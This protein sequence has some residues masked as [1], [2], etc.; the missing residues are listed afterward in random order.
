MADESQQGFVMGMNSAY[1]SLGNIAG[2]IVAGILFDMDVNFPYAAAALVMVLCFLMSL[3]Y[4]RRKRSRR[5]P[6]MR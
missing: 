5:S 6:V 2:P 3:S 1:T 4:G